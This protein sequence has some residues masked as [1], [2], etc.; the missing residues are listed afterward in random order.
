[1]RDFIY[2]NG[3]DK[4]YI[5]Q[6]PRTGNVG[7]QAPSLTLKD[8]DFEVH[9][10]ERDRMLEIRRKVVHAGIR[11][12]II[13]DDPEIGEDW[14]RVIYHPY[15]HANFVTVDDQKPVAGAELV[16]LVVKD[17]SAHMYLE[18]KGITYG[19]SKEPLRPHMI[20][21]DE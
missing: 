5:V 18:P 20:P 11:G 17:G 21:E 6:N 8:V 10:A 7:R 4:E 1:M 12:E 3:D 16:R 2:W 19:D 15:E 13:S 14:V 9:Q